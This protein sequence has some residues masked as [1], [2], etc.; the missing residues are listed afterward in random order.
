MIYPF[1]LTITLTAGAGQ[2]TLNDAN[3]ALAGMPAWSP[4][5]LTVGYY[6]TGLHLAANKSC[7]VEIGYKVSGTFKPLLTILTTVN[8][9]SGIV[10]E[11]LGDGLVWPLTDAVTPEIRVTE[12]GVASDVRVAG[13]LKLFPRAT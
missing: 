6:L 5:D 12:G 7:V 8:S 10:H 11:D 9:G 13:V 3:N 1:D 2:E 4:P